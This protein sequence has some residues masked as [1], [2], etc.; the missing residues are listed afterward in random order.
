MQEVNLT[1]DVGFW[2]LHPTANSRGKKEQGENPIHHEPTLHDRPGKFAPIASKILHMVLYGARA[3]RKICS[4]QSTTW[5][6]LSTGGRLKV[7]SN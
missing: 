3:A 1:L 5:Q 6:D 2:T 7:I 4:E